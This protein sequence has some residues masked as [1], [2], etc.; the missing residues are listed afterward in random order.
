MLE[1][2]DIVVGIIAGSTALD[3]WFKRAWGALEKTQVDRSAGYV[4]RQDVRST[5][6]TV[7]FIADSEQVSRQDQHVLHA[8][9]S[10]SL[11]L[12]W[13]THTALASS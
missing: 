6:C 7:P 3:A 12:T 5:K 10:H 13:S 1:K 11:R 8:T 9:D 2:Y 4:S